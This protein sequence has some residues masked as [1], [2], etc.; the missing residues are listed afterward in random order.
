MS[1]RRIRSDFV[2]VLTRTQ[3]IADV[4][5]R[6]AKQYPEARYQS[7]DKAAIRQELA[8]LGTWQLTRERIDAI[9]GNGHWTK[10]CCDR[11]GAD[12]DVLFQIGQEPDYD[13]RYVDLCQACIREIAEIAEPHP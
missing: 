12:S 3:L 8:G 6:W 1:E 9:I 7:D 4:P 2:R 5:A 10:Q 11:C 13:A